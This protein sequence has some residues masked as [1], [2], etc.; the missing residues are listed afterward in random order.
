[1]VDTVSLHVHERVDLATILANTAKRL[2]SKDAA[3]Q[4]PIFF[5]RGLVAVG[6]IVLVSPFVMYVPVKTPGIRPLGDP[7]GFSSSPLIDA[8]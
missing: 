7:E 4:C 5:S 6:E 2:S 3:R 1:M 8:R